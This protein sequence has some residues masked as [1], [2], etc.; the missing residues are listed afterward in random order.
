MGDD[1][2]SVAGGAGLLGA[3]VLGSATVA[4]GA[5]HIF[6]NLELLHYAALHLLQAQFHAQA[7]VASPLF[8][9]PCLSASS[10]A[11]EGVESVSAEDVAEH[12]ED[13]VHVHAGTAAETAEAAGSRSVES[14]LVIL[15]SLLRVVQHVVSLGRLLEFLFGL[16][17]AGV[18]VGVIFDGNLA[19]CFLDF[20]L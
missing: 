19:V 1:T 7:Q 2:A 10:S 14:E 20:V 15:L 5:G 12:G 3:A 16:F 9:G 11:T 4:V 18:A 13:V 17:V 6:S 8:L